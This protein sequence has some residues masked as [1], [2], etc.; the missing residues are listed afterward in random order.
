[1][2]IDFVAVKNICGSFGLIFDE[3]YH[4][5]LKADRAASG[6]HDYEMYLGVERGIIRGAAILL[7][8]EYDVFY[9][10]YLKWLAM[11]DKAWWEEERQTK[12]V[13]RGMQYAF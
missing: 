2:D 13:R 5:H 3:A 10:V 6:S 11:L 7:G 1:M 8:V 4:Y 9:T 12:M